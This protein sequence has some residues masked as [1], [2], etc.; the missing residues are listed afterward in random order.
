MKTLRLTVGGVAR[1]GRLDGEAV[2]LLDGDPIAGAARDTGER[3]PLDGADLLPPCTPSKIVGVGLNYRAHAVET[4]KP[5]PDEPLL[6][7][8]PPSALLAHGRPIA[9]PRG[10]ARVDYEGEL[11][12]VIGRRARR[13]SDGEALAH[14]YGLTILNDVTVR[15][16]QKKDGQFTRAKGFDTF[17]PLGPWIA[18][19]LDPRDL[20]IQTRLGG[21]TRQD[22]RTSDMVFAVPRIVSF[23]SHVMTLEP[24][25]VI[26]TGTPSGHGNLTP[27]D[28]VEIEIEG[29]GTLRNP[30]E[31]SR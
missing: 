18:T 19:G 29:I 4:G 26:T 25:D 31:E 6:F 12:V 15:E 30:V 5:I 10:Y 11:A 16:L 28:T 3:V 9:R 24:G 21:V 14:L 27:G 22:S 23:V 7:M 17:C 1:H 13:I 2:A 8:K 20:R